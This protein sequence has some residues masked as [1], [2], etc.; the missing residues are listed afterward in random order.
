MLSRINPEQLPGIIRPYKPLY[1]LVRETEKIL[2]KIP[3]FSKD[4]HPVEFE[5][6][7]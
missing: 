6:G 5:L 2:F 3:L 7:L 1:S 4:I